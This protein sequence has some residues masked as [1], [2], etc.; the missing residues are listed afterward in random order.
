MESTI[1]LINPWFKYFY[2]RL[3]QFLGKWW[4]KQFWL[5]W[6][7]PPSSKD[8]FSQFLDSL[9]LL[10]VSVLLPKKFFQTWKAL[11]GAHWD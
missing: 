8:I 9:D 10:V 1:T 4:R 3:F 2:L 7:L 5:P 6:S 11:R